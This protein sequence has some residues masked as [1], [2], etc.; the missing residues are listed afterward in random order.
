MGL[1]RPPTEA[2]LQSPGFWRT[3]VDAENVLALQRSLRPCAR[4]LD[5]GL[6][7]FFGFG[8]A[9]PT[10]RFLGISPELGSG[11]AKAH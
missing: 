8:L 3:V 2:A 10:H 4:K 7:L 6:S 5:Q 11:P 9:G 1:M